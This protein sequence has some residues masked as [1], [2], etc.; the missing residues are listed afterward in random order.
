MYKIPANIGFASNYIHYLP[1]C[2]STNEAATDLLTNGL[3]EG[4]LVITDN[5]TNGKGQRGNFW[6]AEPFKNL[7]FSLILK[8]SFLPIQNQFKLTQIISTG[9]ASAVQSFVSKTVKI[10][11]PNDIYV[12]NKK[13]GGILIQNN[14][15][16]NR[17]DYS[18]I[19]I[20][21]NVNQAGFTT[22]NAIS[23]M[24][25]LGESLDL[26]KVLEELT[27]SIF[28]QYSLLKKGETKHIE[29]E[30]HQLLYQLKEFKNYEAKERFVGKIIGVDPL[31]RL[32][33][34]TGTSVKCFQNQE[35]KFL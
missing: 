12:G 27:S 5:Q 29:D 8:P 18:V 11:W 28:A 6:E 19:G 25:M 32:L 22:P 1:S 33:I 4:T 10:K 15:K 16:G 17:I 2:H 26:N 30:Y 3:E 23:L 31:G 9:I 24:N 7:T 34:E 14:V 35:V 21:L 20:G 13:V